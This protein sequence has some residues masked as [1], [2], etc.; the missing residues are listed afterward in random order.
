M[1]FWLPI[2][3]PLIKIIHTFRWNKKFFEYL[4][5]VAKTRLNN[6]VYR[7]N[8]HSFFYSPNK[9]YDICINNKTNKYVILITTK[10]SADAIFNVITSKRFLQFPWCFIDKLF[11]WIHYK[12]DFILKEVKYLYVC[13]YTNAYL[14]TNIAL[15]WCLTQL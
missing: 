2:K 8:A 9:F 5:H 11:Y 3:C 13:W 12:N 7:K 10:M 14:R 4:Q 6:N 15:L 1:Q